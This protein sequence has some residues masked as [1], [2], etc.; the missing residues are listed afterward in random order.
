MDTGD[1]TEAKKKA[2]Q[3]VRSDMV[4]AALMMV[5]DDVYL[6]SDAALEISIMMQPDNRDMRDKCLR[7]VP[8]PASSEVLL[9]KENFPYDL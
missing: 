4:N 3:R 1:T 9:A 8:C 2:F 6:T 7:R 5:Q